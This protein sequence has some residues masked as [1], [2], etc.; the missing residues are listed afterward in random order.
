LY[1]LGIHPNEIEFFMTKRA[2]KVYHGIK[3]ITSG[4]EE[5]E[6]NTKYWL[7]KQK[8]NKI[9]CA[10]CTTLINKEMV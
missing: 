3:D 7:I 6:G 4:K 9:F 2:E 10:S 1:Q 5:A 8:E